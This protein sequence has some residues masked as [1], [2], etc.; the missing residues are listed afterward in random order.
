MIFFHILITYL[1]V[2]INYSMYHTVI[3]QRIFLKSLGGGVPT[4]QF[5]FF[6][7]HF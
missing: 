3:S 7:L 1:C 6:V 4:D 2:R 5:A